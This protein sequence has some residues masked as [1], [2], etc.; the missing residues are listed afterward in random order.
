MSFWLLQTLSD[1]DTDLVERA[2]QPPAVKE[3]HP[4]RWT[5][6]I[7][8]ALALAVGLG[9]GL[10][11]DPLPVEPAEPIVPSQSETESTTEG[12]VDTTKIEETTITTGQTKE[13]TTIVTAK[14]T[15]TKKP[16]STKTK[17]TKTTN[18]TTKTT[19]KSTTK[20]TENKDG[21]G[22]DENVCTVHGLWYH[23]I[24]FGADKVGEK[25]YKGYFASRPKYESL[26]ESDRIY[27]ITECND[28]ESNI[29]SYVQYCGVT[30]E[31]FIEYMG[32][33]TFIDKMGLTAFLNHRYTWNPLEEEF[34]YELFTFGEYL[35][36]IY[37]DN[38]RL[39][40][41][42]FNAHAAST[43]MSAVYYSDDW[44]H[45]YHYQPDD[46]YQNPLK[47][48]LLSQ[49]EWKNRNPYVVYQSGLSPKKQNIIEFLEFCHIDREKYIEIYG[50]SDKLD[51]KATE[52]FKYAPYTYRQFVD[53]IYGDDITLRAWVF[54]AY[55]FHPDYPTLQEF[56]SLTEQDRFY[57]PPPALDGYIETILTC[58][59]HNP[60]YHNFE[61]YYS[62]KQIREF[63]K[64]FRDR[65]PEELNIINFVN[66]YGITREEFIETIG[67]ALEEA[68]MEMQWMLA[69]RHG[70]NCPY[71]YAEFVDAIFGNDPE[72]VQRVFAPDEHWWETK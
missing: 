51:E 52:H 36:A 15:T 28:P 13:T 57:A 33:D 35:D 46:Y 63:K 41:W 7:A 42:V 69:T 17:P 60:I 68:D 10:D 58:T 48:Y 24:P 62:G 25:L 72:L 64:A 37:G 56:A 49:E 45:Q 14:P 53:A 26:P 29:V 22:G 16:T 27:P 59:D 3:R 43:G 38:P 4:I 11:R 8:A 12:T 23:T 9:F 20:P 18:S 34:G 44:R 47:N 54:G 61:T 21:I 32:W 30:R 39:S 2:A 6:V 66:Y 31:E 5:A 50:W 40:E 19:T 67:F 71:T 65:D 70:N 55:V 1:V